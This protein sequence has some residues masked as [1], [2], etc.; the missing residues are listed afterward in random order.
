MDQNLKSAITDKLEG[1]ADETGRQL[2]DYVEFLESKYNRSRRE[3]TALE[4]LADNL[5]DTLRATRIGA[6]AVK[7]TSQILDTAGDV[8]R[9]VA[10]AG[11]AVVEEI[12]QA[13]EPSE[14]ATGPESTETSERPAEETATPEEPEASAE[15]GAPD[16]GQKQPP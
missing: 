2:L 8:V 14:A 16:E 5:E 10:A 7:G 12:Q 6:A 3:R 11:R 4:R 9:G 1:L 15:T 13:V